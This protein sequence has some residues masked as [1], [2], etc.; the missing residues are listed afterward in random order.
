MA[1]MFMSDL[2]ITS[3]MRKYLAMVAVTVVRPGNGIQGNLW[4]LRDGYGFSNGCQVKGGD[5]YDESGRNQESAVFHYAVRRGAK[6]WTVRA[7]GPIKETAFSL[8]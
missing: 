7:L 3:Y 2:D 1:F 4:E 5:K 8:A 6:S